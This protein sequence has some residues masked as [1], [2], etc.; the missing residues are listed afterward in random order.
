M[1]LP[2]HS[3]MTQILDNAWTLEKEINQ[4]VAKINTDFIGGLQKGI[5]DGNTQL[6]QFA[7]T[8]Q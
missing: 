2:N 4:V 3:Y 5:K 8:I 1:R 6:G 7:E